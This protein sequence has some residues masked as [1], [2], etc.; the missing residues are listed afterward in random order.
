VSGLCAG[1]VLQ[2]ALDAKRVKVTAGRIFRLSLPDGWLLLLGFGSLIGAAVC[3][4]LI[5]HFTGSV[6]NK[7]GLQGRGVVNSYVSLILQTPSP[8]PSTANPSH[9]HLTPVSPRPCR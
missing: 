8:P 5:P 9:R 6:V 1:V 3:T 7:V 2:A 4:T